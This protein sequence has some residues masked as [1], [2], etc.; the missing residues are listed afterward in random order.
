MC[1]INYRYIILVAA[2]TIWLVAWG[3][4]STFSVFLK[5]ISIDT[6]WSRADLALAF[7]LSS[8]VQA[9]AALVMGKITDRLGPRFLVIIF[10]SFIGL[11]YFLLSQVTMLF[12]F[13][14]V[15]AVVGGI[16]LSTATIPIMTTI[17][18]WFSKKRGTV[19]GFAQ[20][21]MGVGGLIFAPLTGWLI[22]NY[23]WQTAYF[24]LGL[25][26]L[27]LIL[28]AGLALKKAP[29]E[30]LEIPNNYVQNMGISLNT[31]LKTNQFWVVSGLFFCFGFCRATFL[32]HTGAYVQDLGFSLNDGA[33]IMA[34]LTFSSVLG[35]VGIGFLGDKVGCRNAY[36]ITFLTMIM[37]FLCAKLTE[38]LS[39]LFLFALLFGFSWGG[40][41]VLRFTLSAEMF[42]LVSLGA[43]TGF[44]GLTEA[45]AAALGSFIGGYIF[46]LFGNYQIIF[47]LGLVFSL[48]GLVLMFSVKPVFHKS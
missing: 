30:K 7:S 42:G 46:D 4:Y 27:P 31:A 43:I 23:N 36:F 48:V 20:S 3:T 25:I 40:Q 29:K 39:V 6:G 28:L 37:A 1:K 2:F 34:M 11:S 41:A 24:C 19:T 15:Y 33:N 13:Q 12:Q 9:I 47:T 8:M 26:T 5:P 14:F 22:M 44:L 35:R 21:G 32:A 45:F 18:R 38:T 17:A 16:G 10:G